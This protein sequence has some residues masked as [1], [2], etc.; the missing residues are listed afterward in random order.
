MSF[1]LQIV[2]GL[3]ALSVFYSFETEARFKLFPKNSSPST[4]L[5]RPLSMPSTSQALESHRLRPFSAASPASSIVTVDLHPP[6]ST[7]SSDS[8]RSVSLQ[9]LNKANSPSIMRESH[10]L[11]RQAAS[12]LNLE[13]IKIVQPPANKPLRRLIPNAERMNSIAKY[14]KNSGIG[15]AAA[16]GA[17]TLVDLFL[18]KSGE[19]DKNS[20]EHIVN[21]ATTTTTTTRPELYNPIGADK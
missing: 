12:T 16:G 1:Q 8:Y 19:K 6:S 10:S 21:T 15:V 13:S 4:V 11:H 5:Q 14:I 18:S 7:L 9:S 3:L 17:V 2:F 20:D